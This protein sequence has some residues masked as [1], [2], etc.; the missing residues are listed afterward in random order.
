[1]WGGRTTSEHHLKRIAK[2]KARAEI[3]HRLDFQ[4]HWGYG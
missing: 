3:L 2:N 1:M 4:I